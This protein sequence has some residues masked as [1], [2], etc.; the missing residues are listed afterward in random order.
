MASSNLHLKLMGIFAVVYVVPLLIGL[1]YFTARNYKAPARTVTLATVPTPEATC[2]VMA[3]DTVQLY[4]RPSLQA[5]VFGTFEVG[6]SR[7]LGGRTITGWLGF[8]PGVAQ[9]PNV[10]PFRLR[11]FPP[12]A[13]VTLS[14]ACNQLKLY[15]ELPPQTCFTMAQAD[16]PI[17]QAPNQSSPVVAH[18]GFGDYV[19]AVG[20]NMSGANIWVKVL[21]TNGTLPAGT[22]GWVTDINFNGDCQ[23]LPA[24]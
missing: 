19:E 10:G 21:S 6:E 2:M 15:P 23:S 1:V 17:Y 13:P 3:N 18:M 24:L 16:V 8:E 20:Q 22:T 11:W 9:A 12:G 4:D 7:A 5:S 14:G